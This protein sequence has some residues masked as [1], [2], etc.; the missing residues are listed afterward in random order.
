MHPRVEILVPPA[1][2]DQTLA[3]MSRMD[4]PPEETISTAKKGRYESRVPNEY[5]HDNSIVLNFY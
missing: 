3:H 4:K 2:L 1:M 5:S